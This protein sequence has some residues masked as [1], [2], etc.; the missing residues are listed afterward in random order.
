M[1]VPLAQLSMPTLNRGGRTELD[2]SDKT[3]SSR[4]RHWRHRTTSGA[5]EG[6]CRGRH[7]QKLLTSWV[8]REWRSRRSD[9]CLTL[10]KTWHLNT[11]MHLSTMCDR[12]TV[13]RVKTH[14]LADPVTFFIIHSRQAPLD[15]WPSQHLS[16][17]L[18]L[19]CDDSKIPRARP[20]SNQRPG[21]DQSL[22]LLLRRNLGLECSTLPRYKCQNMA[23]ASS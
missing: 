6:E 22:L 21:V 4:R 23:S 1:L 8:R 5:S 15:D 3:E 20:I 16:C 11:V 7:C 14:S 2:Q 18:L 13:T 12:V 10:A 9:R 17:S 19:L